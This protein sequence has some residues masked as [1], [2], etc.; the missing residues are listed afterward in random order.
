MSRSLFPPETTEPALSEPPRRDPVLGAMA[1]TLRQ[2]AAPTR[3]GPGTQ[4]KPAVRPLPLERDSPGFGLGRADLAADPPETGL[5]AEVERPGLWLEHRV[6]PWQRMGGGIAWATD[7]ADGIGPAA[8]ALGL[9]ARSAFFV[10]VATRDLD[11]AFAA[12]FGPRLERVAAEG[13]PAAHSVRGLDSLRGACAGA[14][15]AMLGLALAVGDVLAAAALALLVVLNAG[16]TLMRLAALIAGL[17]AHRATP[18]QPVAMPRRPADWPEMSLLIPLL[19]EAG[20]IGPLIEALERLHYP[21]DRLDVKFVVEAHDTATRQALAG[22]RLPAWISVVVVPT[23][24]PRTKPRALN[25]AL[26]LCR[27]SVVGILDAEDA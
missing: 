27:G 20:M 13:L 10:E 18:T 4:A 12:R 3:Q 23:G 2:A 21:R 24:R 11:D 19:R 1:R 9:D 25:Y 17:S 16:T 6:L 22:R 8:A 7:R 26:S 5:L 14:I 15:I